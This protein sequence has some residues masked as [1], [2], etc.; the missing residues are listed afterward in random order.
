MPRALSARQDSPRDARLEE[1]V[2]VGTCEVLSAFARYYWPANRG[3]PSMHALAQ[4]RPLVDPP[5]GGAVPVG[6]TMNARRVAATG[7]VRRQ[8]R[9]MHTLDSTVTA[10]T[11]VLLTPPAARCQDRVPVSSSGSVS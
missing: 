5:M 11:P 7:R 10:E 6:G 3:S 1:A 4:R 9:R 8:L 2:C